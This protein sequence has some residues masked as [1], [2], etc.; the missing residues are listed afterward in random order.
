M[1]GN[2][3]VS[4]AA[5][6]SSAEVVSLNET[7]VSLRSETEHD[8]TNVITLLD[9]RIL[10]KINMIY[11]HGPRGAGKAVSRVPGYAV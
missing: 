6:V 3:Y 4:L 11:S 5:A 8:F 7:I 1:Q 2:S 9:M 10:L